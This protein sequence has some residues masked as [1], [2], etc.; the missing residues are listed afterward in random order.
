MIP[1]QLTYEPTPPIAAYIVPG[2]LA[3]GSCVLLTDP[4]EDVV[5]LCHWGS[6]RALGVP[7]TW[8]GEDVIIHAEL[9]ELPHVIG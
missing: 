8:T 1:E 5:G 2:D 7:A 4:I 6:H 9:V 3:P